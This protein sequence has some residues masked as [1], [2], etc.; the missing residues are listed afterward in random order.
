MPAKITQ[1]VKAHYTPDDI[2]VLIVADMRDR[3]F[4]EI[5]S[6]DLDDVE[7]PDQPQP[8]REAGYSEPFNGFFI[9]KNI[10]IRSK[11]ITR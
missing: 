8:L 2:K 3:G 1:V 5:V 7:N 6:A 11:P 10:D 9:T 4:A